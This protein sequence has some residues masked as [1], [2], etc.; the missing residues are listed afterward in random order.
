MVKGKSQNI[1]KYIE[2]L[3]DM[4]MKLKKKSER[5]MKLFSL[6]KQ[7]VSQEIKLEKVNK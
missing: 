2:N 3:R 6:D 7:M 5:F 1:R 4:N